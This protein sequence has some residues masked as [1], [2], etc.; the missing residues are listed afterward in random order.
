MEQILCDRMN[1]MIKNVN[2]P[3]DKMFGRMNETLFA[4]AGIVNNPKTDVNDVYCTISD[5]RDY[6]WWEIN[7]IENILSKEKMDD[8][9]IKITIPEQTKE[10]INQLIHTYP[11]DINKYK[12]SNKFVQLLERNE[13]FVDQCIWS[14]MPDMMYINDIQEELTSEPYYY[15]HYLP[16]F[17]NPTGEKHIGIKCY[18]IENE[19]IDF[20]FYDSSD[21]VFGIRNLHFDL[22][23][24]I[25]KKAND[26]KNGNEYFWDKIYY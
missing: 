1:S 16:L 12:I 9:I 7:E 19:V 3:I 14:H 23:K 24:K 20:V 21:S 8:D 17:S 5:D 25:I 10:L 2:K 26:K 22:I 11:L 18:D 4:V 13:K 6:F 15:Q